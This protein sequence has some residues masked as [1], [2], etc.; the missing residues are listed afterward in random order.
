MKNRLVKLPCVMLITS[1]CW[2]QPSFAEDLTISGSITNS[3]VLAVSSAGELTLSS[4][5]TR[6]ASDEAGG[7]AANMTVVAT[8]SLPTI[9]FTAPTLTGPSGASGAVMGIAYTSASGAIQTM[10]AVETVSNVTEL[11]DSYTVDGE[12][13]MPEG[14]PAGDYTITTIATCGQ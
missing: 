11:L 7:S 6:M 1:V 9:T 12:I 10:T 13:N 2:S 3:C 5:G 8:G 14:F 4:D